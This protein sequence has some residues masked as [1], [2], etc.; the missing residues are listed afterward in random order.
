MA[1]I[2]GKQDAFRLYETGEIVYEQEAWYATQHRATVLLANTKDVHNADIETIRALAAEKREFQ[3]HL[4]L[5]ADGFLE[6]HV[7]FNKAPIP[8]NDEDYD[9]D[10]YLRDAIVR[11]LGCVGFMDDEIDIKVRSLELKRKED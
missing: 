2:D 7:S 11:A 5:V 4:P 3:K 1:V 9:A 6:I 8:S 10:T